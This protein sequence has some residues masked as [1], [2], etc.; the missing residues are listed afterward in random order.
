MGFFLFL[1]V[2]L[3]IKKRAPSPLPKMAEV[4]AEEK[5]S[6]GVQNW[7]SLF[8][9]APPRP[10]PLKPCGDERSGCCLSTDGRCG[11]QGASGSAGLGG[12]AWPV[13]VMRPALGNLALRFA[14]G[15]E[16]CAAFS[17]RGLRVVP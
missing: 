15:R 5:V 7:R 9:K 2:L 14:Q 4:S 17:W 11:H 6:F 1:D 3:L 8:I 12:D 13:R 16:E 10:R